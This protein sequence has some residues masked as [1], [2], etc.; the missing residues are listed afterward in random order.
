MHLAGELNEW[1]GIYNPDFCFPILSFFRELWLCSGPASGPHSKMSGRAIHIC[2]GWPRLLVGIPNK[3]HAYLSQKFAYIA[4]LQRTRYSWAGLSQKFAYIA[5]L[6]RT[7]YSW[8]GLKHSGRPDR[9]G[10]TSR[11][12]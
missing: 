4:A 1:A 6:Q 5:A 3:C 10:R 8:A 11:P 7:R 9:R 2:A 12:A